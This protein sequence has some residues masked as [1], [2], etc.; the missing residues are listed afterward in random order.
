MTIRRRVSFLPDN[1]GFH[2]SDAASKKQP[3][4]FSSAGDSV[5]LIH[6]RS[7]DKWL[8]WANWR[9]PVAAAR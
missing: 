9:P 2:Y 7:V 5:M 8:V 6:H 4:H 1:A 3:D